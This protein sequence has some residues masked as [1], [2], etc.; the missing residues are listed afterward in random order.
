MNVKK[1][2][3]SLFI[4]VY[5]IPILLLISCQKEIGNVSEQNIF[6]ATLDE[7]MRVAENHLFIDHY[8]FKKSKEL[9]SSRTIS[10]KNGI[11]AYYILN[12]EVG[13]VIISADKRETPILAY[14]YDNN[15]PLNAYSYPRGLVDW[16]YFTKQKIE[17]VRKLNEEQSVF[18][19]S[20][21]E[22][23]LTS[24]GMSGLKKE[25]LPSECVD[26]SEIKMPLLS[27]AWSQWYGFNDA[28][29]VLGCAEGD[30]DFRA[31]AGCVAVAMGQLMK[32]HEFPNDYNW[33]VIPDNY[34][35]IYTSILLRD[36]GDAVNMEYDCEGSSANRDQIAASLIDDFGFSSAQL[37]DYS[38][39]SN[40]EVVKSE[41]RLNNPVIFV[42]GE[43][44]YY[45]GIFPYYDNG[46][47][48]ICDGFQSSFFCETGMTLLIFHMNWGWG[49]LADGWYG[50]GS[51]NPTV[52]DNA[53]D[54]DYQSAVIVNIRK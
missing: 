45:W 34:G 35:N 46:H 8:G 25:P 27:T 15:F 7:T 11:T 31:P 39:T 44:N 9:K 1:S 52:G 47:S 40:Y 10:D 20:Q 51:F 16:L 37:I 18:I 30:G 33:S 29:P 3:F 26:T 42:G 28:A 53:Y 12:Y 43:L 50:F 41:L 14:S 4:V 2:N 54:F 38:G 21:W 32:Y 22:S 5:L 49:G 24:K 13:F 19:K 48:W 6:F 36:I 23:Y 17:K